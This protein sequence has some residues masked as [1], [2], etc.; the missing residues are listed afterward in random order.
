MAVCFS[1]DGLLPNF[2]HVRGHYEA[3][4]VERPSVA[5]LRGVR[6]DRYG[7]SASP[8]IGDRLRPE[9]AFDSAGIRSVAARPRLP[10]VIAWPALSR[11]AVD[12]RLPRAQRGLGS[13]PG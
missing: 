11:E 5:T 13:C 10:R 1:S 6:L 3:S 7:C 12:Q 9:W 4:E 8:G 2:H